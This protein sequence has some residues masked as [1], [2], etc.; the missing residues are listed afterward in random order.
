ML[1]MIGF[2]L[3]LFSVVSTS[4]SPSLSLAAEM[5]IED[6]WK[7]LPKY[8][9]GKDM[10]ALLTI[11]REVIRAMAAP[12]SRSAC[13]TRLAA[14]LEAASTTRAA[15]QYICLQLRQVGSRAEVPLLTRLLADPRASQMARYALESIPGEE[16]IAA[17]RDAMNTLHGDSLIG[18]I[19]SVAARKDVQSVAS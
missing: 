11:D 7:A 1:R 10:A 19:N 14:L 18:V 12:A 4:T 15:K 16:S 6:A 8:E 5:P 13:A 9:Y 3:V 2:S 17:L